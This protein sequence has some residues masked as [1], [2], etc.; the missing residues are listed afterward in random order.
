MHIYTRLN[1]NIQNNIDNYIKQN[2]KIL[3]EQINNEITLYFFK[4]NI[5]SIVKDNISFTD[6]GCS[7]F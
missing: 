6:I 2:N 7:I 5:N 3:Q 1:I 4:K